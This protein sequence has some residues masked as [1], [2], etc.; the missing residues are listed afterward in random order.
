MISFI[1]WIV[2]EPIS[3]QQLAVSM[4]EKDKVKDSYEIPGREKEEEGNR[5]KAQGGF[6]YRN[7]PR[8]LVF[9]RICNS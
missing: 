5:T 6:R 7:D 2:F 3:N 4:V 9:N 1:Y 8:I